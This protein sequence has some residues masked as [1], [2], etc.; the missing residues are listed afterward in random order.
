MLA[1]EGVRHAD[2][3]AVLYV[4]KRDVSAC[5]KVPR[6]RS[7]TFEKMNTIS[8]AEVDA[9][10]FPRDGRGSSETYPRAD[11]AASIERKKK[12]PKLPV[13]LMWIEYCEHAASQKKVAYSYLT[14]CEM[15]YVEAEQLDAT[16]HFRHEPSAKAYIDCPLPILLTGNGQSTCAKS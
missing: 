4:S 15:F 14:S 12:S 8:A 11:L 3:V 13:T 10:F 6:E 1:K 2:V 7:L 5:T 9:G 16:R